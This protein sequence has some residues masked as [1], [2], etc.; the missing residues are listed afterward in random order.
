MVSVFVVQLSLPAVRGEECSPLCRPAHVTYEPTAGDWHG[1]LHLEPCARNQLFRA[2]RSMRVE[3]ALARVPDDAVAVAARC[4]T[5]SVQ[6]QHPASKDQAPPATC[7]ASC[8]QTSR[9]ITAPPVNSRLG[10]PS[11]GQSAVVVLHLDSCIHTAHG[12]RLAGPQAALAHAAGRSLSCPPGASW[13][14]AETAQHS[15]VPQALAEAWCNRSSKGIDALMHHV[16]AMQTLL[17]WSAYA[18]KHVTPERTSLHPGRHVPASHPP[19]PAQSR[20]Q[21]RAFALT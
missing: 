1:T 3:F 6:L 15:C 19:R 17:L 16:G 5:T 7:R 4:I 18:S 21:N 10:P 11:A 20:S 8:S 2:P 9:W 13:Q 14:H 12:R